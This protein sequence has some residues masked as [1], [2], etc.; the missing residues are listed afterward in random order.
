[1]LNPY[2][3]ECPEIVGRDLVTHEPVTCG[4]AILRRYDRCVGHELRQRGHGKG[5]GRGGR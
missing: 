4:R 3:K 1:M 5:H 2:T